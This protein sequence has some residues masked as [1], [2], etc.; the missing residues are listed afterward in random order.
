MKKLLIVALAVVGFVVGVGASVAVNSGTFWPLNGP[1]VPNL[2]AP[3]ICNDE[4]ILTWFDTNGKKTAFSAAAGAKGDPGT[5][6]TIAAGTVTTGA[7]AAVKNSGTQNAAVFD[8][9]IP[10][11]A[12]GIQGIQGPPGVVV[13]TVLTGTF[14]CTNTCT[15]TV[16]GIK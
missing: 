3:G 14:S 13:G 12:Q 15:F 4:G 10:A 11:G 16:T 2:T 8:F 5:A 7:P 6:A 9:T 1:C